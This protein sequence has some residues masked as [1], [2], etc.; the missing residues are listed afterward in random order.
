MSFRR[1]VHREQHRLVALGDSLAQG[2]KNG[3]VFR[4]DISF[5]AIL[6]RSLSPN[7]TF[8]APS[9]TPRGGIP[10]NLEHLVR[11]IEK[12]F[13]NDL[14]RRDYPRIMLHLF[15]TLRDSKE[16]WEDDEH[17]LGR[18]RVIPYHNQAVWGFAINDL[19]LMNDQVC[20]AFLTEQQDRYSVFSVLPD[21][22]MY[23]TGRLV[24]NPG[25]R[26]ENLKRTQLKNLEELHDRGGVENLILNVGHN[27]SVGALSALKIRYSQP[28]FMEKL[29]HERTWTVYR[30][31]HFR[32]EY[33][34]LCKR[35]A[36]LGIRRVFLPTIPYM[37]IPPVTRGINDRSN[38][39]HQGYFDYYTRFWIWDDEFNPD[40]H[41]H[42][43]K[44]DAMELD[45]LVDEYNFI[46]KD[47]AE[48]YD[49]H[50]VPVNRYVHAVARRRLGADAVRPFPADFVRALKDRPETAHLVRED[51]R[52]QLSTDY[53]RIDRQTHQITRGGIFSLD[54][55]H[56]TT[57]GYG[58]IANIYRTVMQNAGV[59]FE[60]PIDWDWI[61]RN[62][63]LVTTPPSLLKE[64][65]FLLRFF[66]MGRQEKFA[67]LGQNLLQQL[68]ERV[69]RS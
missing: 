69:T 32:Q 39:E 21:H 8:D 10:I 17:H 53:I 36:K 26:E 19:W 57:I 58:L 62:E 50:L 42:L 67:F 52:V 46:L 9:F 60:A 15:R 11:T 49:F 54:G 23:I 28:G 33:E 22:A 7:H 35:V 65:R 13:G 48:T 66:S 63:T 27:N 18:D 43:T 56:P 38:P 30:P 24:L 47:L 20:H 51:G 2:F 31:E 44:E 6:A 1:P 25:F 45:Q 14:R 16:Y 4:S 5:P 61:I 64:L 40:K 29:H 34:T 59:T 41:P 3:G 12:E 55:L 68:L 37:T